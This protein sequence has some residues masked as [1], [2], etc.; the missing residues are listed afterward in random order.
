MTGFALR[1]KPSWLIIPAL[2]IALFFSL[3]GL[4]QAKHCS[5]GT[6]LSHGRCVP[7]FQAPRGRARTGASAWKVVG[8]WFMNSTFTDCVAKWPH[9][10]YENRYGHTRSGLFYYCRLTPSSGSDIINAGFA[11]TVIGI[12]LNKNGSWGLTLK[13]DDYSGEIQYYTWYVSNRGAAH[14]LHW[15]PG[16][17]PY[18]DPATDSTGALRWVRGARTCAY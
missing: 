9:C 10:R 17:S 5:T 16:T 4:A 14:G 7:I 2:S 6:K 12:T 18:T 8:P 13:A 11:F 1:H 3:P 15:A